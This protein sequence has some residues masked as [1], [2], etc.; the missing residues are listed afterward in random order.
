MKN[1]KLF[2]NKKIIITG[3]TGFKGSWLAAWLK[4]LG[5]DIMG[6]SLKPSTRPS[7]FDVAEIKR[8]IKD[9]RLDIRN[10]KKIE[11]KILSFKPDFIFHLAAQ[12][13]VG[14]SYKNSSLTWETNVIG[15]LNILESL[16][17]LKKKCNVV[18]I[19]SDKCYFNRET[20]KGYKETDILGGKDPYS[21]SKASA[22]IMIKSYIYSFFQN[23]KNIRIATARAG[24][25][26]GGGDWSDNRV[27]PD[28]I[29]SWSKNKIAKLRN[30]NSTRP[31]QHVLEAVGGYLCLAI[32]LKFNKKMHGESFNFGPSLSKEY[33]VLE[34]VKSMS[35]HWKNTR[36]KKVSKLNNNFFE[37][38]LLRL[39]CN[40]AKKYL[41]FKTILKFD[42]LTLM[43]IDWYKNYYSKKKNS[44]T[45]T[46]NQIK[47]YQSL[48]F[49]RGLKWI[50][51]K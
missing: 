20:H 28:C 47:K 30:P 2:K 15:T 24:N 21:A 3:H 16:K 36:W 11:K 1:L 35:G 37:S 23:Q 5:A 9:V 42:E 44:S 22:E 38:G 31:W 49:K 40:K 7:H 17:K 26:I 4:L 10:K 12:A 50:K 39:N 19:T 29:K 45:F 8:G 32:N 51:I 6:I 46:F 41:G 25:V 27:I 14:L 13:L 33:S 34:L 48:A 43:V 18:I